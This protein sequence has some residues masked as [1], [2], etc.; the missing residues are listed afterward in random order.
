MKNTPSTIIKIK[1]SGNKR[2]FAT[3]AIRDAVDNKPMPSEI[4]PF[5]T[6]RVAVRMAGGAKHYG[7]GNWRKGMTFSETLDSLERH[8]LAIKLDLKDE[9]HLAAVVCNANFLMHY[10]EMIKRR[11]L[12]KELDDLPDYTHKIRRK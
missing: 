3:G 7:K 4:S 11:L 8:V 5:A 2:I 1:T 9:D 10:E 12:P 6:L